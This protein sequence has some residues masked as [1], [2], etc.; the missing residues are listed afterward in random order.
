MA[1]TM[2]LAAAVDDEEVDEEQLKDVVLGQFDK[3]SRT[4][5]R[6]KVQLK[7]RGSCLVVLPM[8]AEKKGDRCK[9]RMLRPLGCP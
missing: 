8:S 2:T 7:V 3:V 5:A 9:L 1:M 4:K 6:W